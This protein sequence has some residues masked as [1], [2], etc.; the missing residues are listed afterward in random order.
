MKTQAAS[1]RLNSMVTGKPYGVK[2]LTQDE[3]EDIIYAGLSPAQIAKR[4]D[5]A[6]QLLDSDAIQ[7]EAFLKS[8]GWHPGHTLEQVAA[9]I[10]C[11]LKA[12]KTD[13]SWNGAADYGKHSRKNI[14]RRETSHQ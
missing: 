10:D 2:Q 8:I 13:N 6:R 11:A 1:A 14:W 7:A 9:L 12:R 4:A 3:V 5:A